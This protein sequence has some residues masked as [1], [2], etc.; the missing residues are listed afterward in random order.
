MTETETFRREVSVEIAEAG[1]GRTLVSRLVPYNEIATVNDG[2]GPY[3]ETFVPGAFNKQ[4]SAANRIKAFLNFRHSRSLGDQIG[5][6]T[7]IEDRDD[8]LH[9]ELRVLETV[10]GDTALKLYEA[11]VLNKLSIEFQ[12]VRDK[13]VNGVVHRVAARLLG[14]ALVPEGA[15][16]GAAVLAVREDEDGDGDDGDGGGADEVAAVE[17][18]EAFAL[19]AWQPE[20]LELFERHGIDAKQR[21][22][23]SKPW[24]GSESRWPDAASYCSACM[25]DNNPSGAEKTKAEC[26]FPYK[27]P[28]GDIS[29]A[30]LRAIVGG[31]GAQ[32]NFPGAAAARAKARRMLA[33][34][35]KSSGGSS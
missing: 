35:N 12:P 22:F 32:A 6:A 15:Y 16:D 34:Y 10:N 19:P 27:E 13:V 30:A 26:H 4:L 11:G 9:G 20:M 25:V 14:V 3:K 2:D 17:E 28:N 1:D 29:V 33:Q 24:D 8:G 5:H 31:R 18:R 21:A 7:K 23:T